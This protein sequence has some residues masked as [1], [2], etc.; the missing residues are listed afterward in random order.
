MTKKY[1]R[2]ARTSVTRKAGTSSVYRGTER[3]LGD[4]LAIAE[5]TP[6]KA[7]GLQALSRR[8]VDEALEALAE[9]EYALNEPDIDRRIAYIGML[10]HSMTI[11]KSAVRQMYAYSRAGFRSPTADGE[12]VTV[13]R[14]G[15]VIS[16][17]QYLHL[18]DQF[19]RLGMEV[20]RW[21]KS[22]Q[23]KRP[24]RTDRAEM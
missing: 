6:K 1:I 3:L 10:V 15:R 8:M 22:S 14:Y 11:L 23:A 18:L 2:M 5:R 24:A 19:A 20:G 21:L 7:L 17:R 16:H 4:L 13:P 12:T 9:T